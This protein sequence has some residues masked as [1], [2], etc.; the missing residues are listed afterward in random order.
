MVKS[1]ERERRNMRTL[2]FTAKA[3]QLK[4]DVSCDFSGLV[5]GSKRVSA[6]RIFFFRRL[7]RMWEGHSIP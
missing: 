1:I 4:K 6:G 2:K 5:K 7:C 3:Q